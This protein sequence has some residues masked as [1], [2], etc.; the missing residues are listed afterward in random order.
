MTVDLRPSAWPEGEYQRWWAI[1]SDADS[2]RPQ[3][4][5]RH[6]AVAT[7]YAAY[8]EALTESGSSTSG[9]GVNTTA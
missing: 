7:A 3:G 4:E 8:S 5:G 1:Q 9:T 2:P 6:G